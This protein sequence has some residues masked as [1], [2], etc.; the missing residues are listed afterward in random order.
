MKHYQRIKPMKTSFTWTKGLFSSLS[1]IYS[2]GKT[3]GNM[4]DI[5]FSKSA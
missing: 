4:E 1:Q 2:N 3:I 5:T